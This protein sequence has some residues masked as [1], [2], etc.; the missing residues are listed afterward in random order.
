M[1]SRIS[2]LQNDYHR[3]T[4]SPTVLQTRLSMVWPTVKDDFRPRSSIYVQLRPS[5]MCKTRSATKHFI[6]IPS[7]DRWSIRE[8]E[9]MGRVVP[10]TSY[11]RSA[12]RLGSMAANSNSSPQSLFECDHQ[13]SPKRSLTRIFTPPRLPLP[14]IDE[15][16]G[17]GAI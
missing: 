4:S 6:S 17:R 13:G 9:P 10:E 14:S 15:R 7:A 8:Q 12:R 11:L 1:S 16:P 5:T 3:G 2:P